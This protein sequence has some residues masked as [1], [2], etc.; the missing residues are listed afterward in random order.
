MPASPPALLGSDPAHTER[1]ARRGSALSPAHPLGEPQKGPAACLQRSA[2]GNHRNR[3]RV[4]AQGKKSLRWGFGEKTACAVKCRAGKCVTASQHLA[5]RQGSLP[6]QQSLVAA[7]ALARDRSAWRWSPNPGDLP[8]LHGSASGKM[9][10]AVQP[11]QISLS[12]ED[13][14]ARESYVGLC[15]RHGVRCAARCSPYLSPES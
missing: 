14:G 11:R 1:G 2:P 9:G 8:Q 13:R 7:P 15:A 10:S 4:K 6:A 3:Q 12:Q 5:V